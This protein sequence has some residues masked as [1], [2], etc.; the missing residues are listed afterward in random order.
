MSIASEG[1][2]ILNRAKAQV[3]QALAGEI[4]DM[5]KNEISYMVQ[6]AVYPAY[7]PTQYKRRG[8]SGGIA[9]KNQ[10]TATNGDMSL[11]VAD[12]RPEVGVVESGVGYTW[13]HSRIYLMQ[14]YPRPYFQQAEENTV[15]DA[16]PM[17]QAI[18]SS[19]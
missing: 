18:L 7:S 12:D 17:I 4:A 1:E 9:D 15:A 19:I 2:A 3:N 6:A 13:E 11:T 8:M 14:P 5:A 16:E 10:Y